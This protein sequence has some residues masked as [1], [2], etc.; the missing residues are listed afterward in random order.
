MDL[1]IPNLSLEGEP[2]GEITVRAVTLCPG[3]SFTALPAV[4]GIPANIRLLPEVHPVLLPVRVRPGP[5]LQILTPVRHTLT[6]QKL[7]PK[8]GKTSVMAFL[9]LGDTVLGSSSIPV[10]ASFPPPSKKKDEKR[11][12]C[13]DTSDWS[14]W[15]NRM[16]PGP[17]SF[18]VV[19]TVHFPS[20]GFRAS[21]E[22]ASPQGINPKQLILDLIVEPLKGRWPG[23]HHATAVRYDVDP[24]N[25]DYTSVLVRVPGGD[26]VQIEVLEVS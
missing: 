3:S 16:P 19:G 26:D 4:V 11:P 22:P 15:V 25:G 10:G 9:M 21:L 14:A 7:G 17:A 12:V 20:P 5:S 1:F 23:Q 6:D 8:H 13:V 18:H 24:F 2:D